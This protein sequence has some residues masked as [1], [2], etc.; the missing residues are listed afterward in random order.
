MLVCPRCGEDAKVVDNVN[1]FFDD[2][3]YR[4]RKCTDCGHI[5]YTVER[6]V[7]ISKQFLDR[8]NKHHRQSY[9][10]KKHKKEVRSD[11]RN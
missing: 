11:G 9:T 7:Q 2:E 10:R 1:N 5:I 8:W 4:K 6:E 3:V